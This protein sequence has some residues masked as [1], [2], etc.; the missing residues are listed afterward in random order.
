MS[1]K[2]ELHKCIKDFPIFHDHNEWKDAFTELNSSPMFSSS[3]ERQSECVSKGQNAMEK[4]NT[5]EAKLKEHQNATH[6][7]TVNH[8]Q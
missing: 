5:L 6:C 1:T 3:F 8:K 7:V 2:K 4:D